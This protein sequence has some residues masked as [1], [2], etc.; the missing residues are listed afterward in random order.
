[1]WHDWQIS[2]QTFDFIFGWKLVAASAFGIALQMTHEEAITWN[3]QKPLA[4]KSPIAV[5]WFSTLRIDPRIKSLAA[6]RTTGDEHSCS[7][8]R[9]WEGLYNWTRP[10]F[11]LWRQHCSIS[12]LGCLDRQNVTTFSGEWSI[13]S[14]NWYLDTRMMISKHLQ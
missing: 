2:G 12:S 4:V 3:S 10:S 5:S 13:A 8:Y 7:G 9:K 11:W 14:Q 6:E 1:M